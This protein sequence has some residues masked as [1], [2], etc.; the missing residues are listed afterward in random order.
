DFTFLQWYPSLDSD[1][2]IAEYR[3]YCPLKGGGG[4]YENDYITVFRFRE[5][6]IVLYREYLNPLQ[7]NFG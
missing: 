5:D 4:V 3:S 7:L 1:V 2:V 6:R